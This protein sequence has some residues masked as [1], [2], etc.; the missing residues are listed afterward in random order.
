MNMISLTFFAFTAVLFFV[1]WLCGKTV[2]SETAYIKLFKTVML[3]ASYLF[4]L[5]AD[6]RFALVLFAMSTVTYLCAKAENGT[7]IGVIFALL[8]LGYFKYTNFFITSFNDILGSE[9]GTLKIILPLGISFYAFSAISYLVD[10]K[11]NKLQPAGFAD[12]ALYLSFFPKITSGPVQRSSD[13]LTQINSRRNVGWD[14]FAAGIQIF[15]FGAFK[16]LVLADRLSVFVNQVYDTP[17]VFSWVS[18]VL[19]VLS[20]SLQIYFDFSG[21]SDMA[22][23]IARIFDI[24]L[25]KNF[26][27]PYISR[28]V[29]ELWKRWHISLSS[30]LQEYLYI[31]LGGNRKGKMRTYIN[32]VLTMVLGGV[33][34][35]ASWNYIL[36]GLLHGAAL[37]VHKLWVSFTHSS[38]KEHSVLA[39]IC[40]TATTFVFVSFCWVFFRTETTGKAFAVLSRIF[41]LADG[42]THLY[43]WFFVAAAVLAASTLAA[44]IKSRGNTVKENRRNTSAVDGFYPLLDLSKFW[45]LVAF[46]VLCGLILGLCYT[47]GSPFIYGAY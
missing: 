27:L 43:L 12:V 17:A 16:K 31:S 32:L 47:G 22:I 25:P 28:N 21:Y 8:C 3:C 20:Y 10:V 1:L 40:S 2:K 38:T 7:K 5:Y 41:T 42:I 14:S 29:T 33:W 24:H 37:A 15:A 30:W 9:I 45:H 36:W 4:V 6:V 46:F 23:G 19:A 35:G 11:R 44:K 34:H 18:V 39:N 26:N 13:F